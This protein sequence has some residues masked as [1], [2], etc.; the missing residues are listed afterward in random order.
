MLRH[1]YV[2]RSPV[3]LMITSKNSYRQ[4]KR[5]KRLWISEKASEQKNPKVFNFPLFSKF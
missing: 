1:L 3:M 5:P 4:G 2:L